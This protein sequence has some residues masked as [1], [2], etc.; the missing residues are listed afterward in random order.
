MATTTDQKSGL[1]EVNG[2]KIYYETRGRG[3]SVIFVSGA[4]GDAGLLTKV[5]DFLADEFTVVTYDRRGNSRSPRPD[6]WAQTSADEQ[7]D[8]LAGLIEV[9]EI[10]PAVIFGTSAGAIIGLNTILRHEDLL[11]GAILHEPAMMSVLEHPE[12]AMGVVQPIVD[13]GMAKGGPRGG[14]EAFLGFAAGDDLKALDPETVDRMLG[15]AEVFFGLEFGKLESW[16]PTE[17]AL[18][19]VKIPVQVMAGEET[20]PFFAE[21]SAWIA[22]RLGRKVVTAIGAHMSYL[23]RPQEFADTI[24]PFLRKLS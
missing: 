5:P 17:D 4:T 7:G 2:A 19:K 15:N 22:Q 8:D 11:R 14:F 6:G 3:P 16:R 12:E 9:L 10:A 24:R 23:N 21:T 18:A 20:A 1:V 13:E